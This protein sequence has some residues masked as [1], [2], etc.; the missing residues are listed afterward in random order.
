MAADIELHGRCG[1][2]TLEKIDA[3]GGMQTDGGTALQ[4]QNPE[5][6]TI[7]LMCTVQ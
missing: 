4:P 5:T 1:E 3:K 7:R 6:A 2:I